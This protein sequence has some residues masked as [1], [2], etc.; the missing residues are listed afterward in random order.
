MTIAVPS[1]VIPQ[2][3]NVRTMQAEVDSDGDGVFDAIDECPETLPNRVVD[4]KGC[5]IIIEG[6]EALE[7]ELQGFFAPLSSRLINTYDKEFKKIEEK[8]NEYLDA[9]VFIFGH[10]SSNELALS[11]SNDN[12]SRQRALTIKNR[13]ITEH[14]IAS[15][16]ITTYDCLDRYPSTNIDLSYDDPEQMESKN[17]R[18]V[19][20]ASRQVKNLSNLKYASYTESYGKYAKHC[21]LFE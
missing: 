19:L 16:R 7:M 8:L 13:L 9:N 2:H 3:E 20:K 4:I 17:R 14:H 6:G 1:K 15:D 18:V 12:L 5:E 10:L 21:E 11:K